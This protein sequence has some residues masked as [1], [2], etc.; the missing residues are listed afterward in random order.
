M[1]RLCAGSQ[2]SLSVEQEWKRHESEVNHSPH[3]NKKNKIFLYISA[4]ISHISASLFQHE[5]LCDTVVHVS[6]CP[7]VY[8]YMCFL[9][10][11]HVSLLSESLVIHLCVCVYL[12]VAISLGYT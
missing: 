11:V 8:L 4:Y 10:G 6:V 9:V 1:L 3:S 2:Y 7:E 12:S 5:P